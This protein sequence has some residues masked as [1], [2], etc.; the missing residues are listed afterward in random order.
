MELRLAL[1]TIVLMLIP[2]A[3]ASGLTITS[4]SVLENWIS[5]LTLAI[6]IGIFIV[7]FIYFAGSLLNSSR[8]KETAINELGQLIGTVIIAVI[9]IA[10]VEFFGSAS[11][12]ALTANTI[13]GNVMQ[14]CQQLSNDQFNLVNSNSI[15]SP[16]NTICAA[17]NK[18][19]SNIQNGGGSGIDTALFADYDLMAS[20]IIVA[21]LT[22]QMAQNLDALYQYEN[23][24]GFLSTLTPNT[25]YCESATPIP[26]LFEAWCIVPINP[27]ALS[28][29]VSF[30]PYKGYTILKE[31][32]KPIEMQGYM[33]F[34][35]YLIELLS[36]ITFI[37]AWPYL[38]AAGIIL[39]ASMFTRRVGGM[40]IGIVIG[41]LIIFPIIFLM[42]YVSLN[43]ATLGPIGA[44]PNTIPVFTMYGNTL[45]GNPVV[46]NSNTINFFVFP[47]ATNIVNYYGCYPYGGNIYLSEL[48]ISAYFMFPGVGIYNLLAYGIGGMVVGSL[49]DIPLTVVS[50]QPQNA[51]T[52][53]FHFADLY[54]IIGVTGYILPII[55][56]LILISAIKGISQLM[57]GDTNLLG[58]GRLV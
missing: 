21:N 35:I 52:L 31:I 14:I 23:Y 11:V 30:T 20:Y 2:L 33:I 18:V 51:L 26:P 15:T 40:L 49:P 36:I 19:Y 3:S 4:F 57:G 45:K 27:R 37:Y 53:I 50:C 1:L 7:S 5:I 22:S 25:T 10:I 29:S 13:G 34:E 55:N 38:L 39:K 16:T 43:N 44:S 47:N 6:L 46:Y 58:L 24:I 48:G 54:G 42:E 28:V 32:S 41:G 17:T 9:I 56:I 12:T 8:I